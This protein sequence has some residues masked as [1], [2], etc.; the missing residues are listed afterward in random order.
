M[1]DVCSLHTPESVQ[2]LGVLLSHRCCYL[3]ICFDFA[4]NNVNCFIDCRVQLVVLVPSVPQVLL[5][6]L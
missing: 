5:V 6:F 1:S 2:D 3:R 4:L